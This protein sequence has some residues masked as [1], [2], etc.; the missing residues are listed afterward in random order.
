MTPERWNPA[1]RRRFLR[2]RGTPAFRAADAAERAVL[3]TWLRELSPRTVLDVASGDGR[4]FDLWTRAGARVYALDSDPAMAAIARSRVAD[5]GDV[6]VTVG[7]VPGRPLPAADLAV[8]VRLLP[9]LAEETADAVLAELV[10]AAPA[11]IVQVNVRDE[12]PD[13]RAISAGGRHRLEELGRLAAAADRCGAVTDRVERLGA[14][15]SSRLIL[16]RRRE[17]A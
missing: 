7:A 16:L 12:S 1:S 8:C 14:A 17:S 9:W 13:A 5:R 3:A 4:L 11:V 10:A 15:S 2:R 6:D